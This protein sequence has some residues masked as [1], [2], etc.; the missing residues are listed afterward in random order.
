MSGDISIKLAV[1]AAPDDSDETL[2]NKAEAQV[3]FVLRIIGEHTA[4]QL[5]ERLA[6]SLG[7]LDESKTAFMDE[8]GID[9]VQ[10]TPTERRAEV[11]D[12]I[13]EQ[14]KTQ[15]ADKVARN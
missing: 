13:F 5:W 15:R 8:A 10:N 4:E 14:L 12:S 6:A 9:M 3:D 1:D 2:R 11:E 7:D